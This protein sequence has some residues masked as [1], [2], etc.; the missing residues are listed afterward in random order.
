M[1]QEN[2]QDQLTH[3]NKYFYYNVSYHLL[4]WPSISFSILQM[5]QLKATYHDGV[6]FCSPGHLDKLGSQDLTPWP[7][8]ASPSAPWTF[9]S[10][11]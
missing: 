4:D 6:L 11:G 1:T 9:I 10:I 2:F 7:S 3:S 8:Q 5:E